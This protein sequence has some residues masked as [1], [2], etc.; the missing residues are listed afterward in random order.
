VFRDL[1][2]NTRVVYFWRTYF[3]RFKISIGNQT[4]KLNLKEVEKKREENILYTLSFSLITTQTDPSHFYLS[5][6]KNTKILEKEAKNKKREKV[7]RYWTFFK[8]R[9]YQLLFFSFNL[10]LSIMFFLN[11]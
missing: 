9:H 2:L 6:K 11:H 1:L 10:F 8:A 3:Q 4:I 7:K 5:W